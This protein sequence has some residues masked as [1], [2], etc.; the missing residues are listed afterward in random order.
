MSSYVLNQ[1]SV[2]RKKY[3]QNYSGKGYFSKH[4]LY[5]SN[6]TESRMLAEAAYPYHITLHISTLY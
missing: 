3:Q 6:Q 1:V 2:T 5:Q 4:V